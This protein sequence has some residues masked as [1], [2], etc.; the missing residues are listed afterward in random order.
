MND[1]I[2]EVKE[3]LN[4]VFESIATHEGETTASFVHAIVSL[5]QI[6]SGLDLI[7]HIAYVNGTPEQKEMVKNIMPT[8]QTIFAMSV[9]EFHKATNKQVDLDK[10][11]DWAVKIDGQ[12]DRSVDALRKK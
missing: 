12:M 7:S 11:L 2:K 4:D 10:C 5:K 8:L 3:S 6:A 1:H 9:S